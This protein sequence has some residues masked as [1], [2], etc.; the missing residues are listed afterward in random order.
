VALEHARSIASRAL[1]QALGVVQAVHNTPF[2]DIVD[3]EDDLQPLVH[4][5]FRDATRA[6]RLVAAAMAG[7][8]FDR[9][10]MRARA[11]QHWITVTELADS[12]ARDRNLPFRVGHEICRR[13]IRHRD[14]HPSAPLS[15]ALAAVTADLPGGPLRY[16]E[17]ALNELLSP[18]HF[19]RVRGTWGGPAPEETAGAIA[20]SRE[21]LARD[22]A[23]I[24]GAR[25]QLARAADRLRE[26]VVA[27]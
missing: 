5:A 14:D 16:G 18:E 8:G 24:A 4:Q 6:V 7:A 12:L 3:T 22:G 2:G 9:D 27:L 1:G 13:L 11:T 26:R 23:W 25:D 17:T 21:R 20:E 10:L 19:V 15:E